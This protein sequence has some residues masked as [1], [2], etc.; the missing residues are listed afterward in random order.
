GQGDAFVIELPYR[1]GVI[2]IDAGAHFSFT[3]FTTSNKVYRR[4]IKPY[5]HSR[6]IN[7]I[8]AIFLSHEDSDHVGSVPFIIEDMRVDLIVM[9]DLYQLDEE[10]KRLFLE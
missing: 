4:I 2:F 7:K 1:K 3:D 5:L 9:S 6:G 10:D 8:D